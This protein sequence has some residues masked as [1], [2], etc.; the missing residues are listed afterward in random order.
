MCQECSYRIRGS[1]FLSCGSDIGATNL[2]GSG[3]KRALRKDHHV[4]K[5]KQG[6]NSTS[7]MISPGVPVYLKSKILA[8]V[9][10]KRTTKECSSSARQKYGH[11]SQRYS[12]FWSYVAHMP[13]KEHVWVETGVDGAY[14]L[15]AKVIFVEKR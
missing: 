7:N 1:P 2:K 8:R 4:P 13:C 3:V 6:V 12:V 10:A 11:R 9:R 14:H 5:T 15:I